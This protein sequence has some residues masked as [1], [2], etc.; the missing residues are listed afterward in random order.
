VE[1]AAFLIEASGA[2]VSCLLNPAGVV[3]RR[4]AGLRPRR[5]LMGQATSEPLADAP[6]LFTG[7][8]VTELELELFFD[9][10]LAGSSIVSGDI[11]D[12]THPLWL[13]SENL[14]NGHGLSVADE[15]GTR[16]PPALRFVWG[17]AWNVPV[18]VAGVAEHLEHF[19]N[20]GVPRRSWLSMRLLRV[21]D[22]TAEGEDYQTPS[23][24]DLNAAALDVV[25]EEV[26]AHQVVGGVSAGQ[27]ER[28]DE[29]ARRFYGDPGY[30][31]LLATFNNIDNPHQ[32]SAGT[33]LQV[34]PAAQGNGTAER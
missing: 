16:R 23:P 21:I 17:K 10:S 34:P 22:P 12:L 6:L 19:T 4:S 31:R 18:V 2:R 29:L 28:L 11:R 33:V 15:R 30:W 32:I 5:S 25:A 7:G 1:R 20:E 24:T 8:G 26:E 14:D 9:T 27:G 13:L 3:V